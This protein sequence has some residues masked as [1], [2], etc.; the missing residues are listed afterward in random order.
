M[1]ETATAAAEHRL[2]P[3]SVGCDD[4]LD[5]FAFGL[6]ADLPARVRVPRMVGLPAGAAVVG[7]QH[8]FYRRTFEFLVAHPSFDPVPVGDIADRVGDGVQQVEYVR[9][10]TLAET[11]VEEFARAVLAWAV[12]HSADLAVAKYGPGH[13]T[14]NHLLPA[15]HQIIREHLG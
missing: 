4:V 8:D 11:D 3:A 5:A 13:G 6:A 15:L 12:A 1:S 9:L 14:G 10:R 7:V 2:K